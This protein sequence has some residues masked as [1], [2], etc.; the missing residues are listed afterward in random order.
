MAVSKSSGGNTSPNPPMGARQNVGNKYGGAG[1]TGNP[2]GSA[3]GPAQQYAP[4]GSPGGSPAAPA[5]VV[6]DLNLNASINQRTNTKSLPE[7]LGDGATDEQ[8]A[9]FWMQSDDYWNNETNARLDAYNQ[10]RLDLARIE[11]MYPDYARNQAQAQ[12]ILDA[13]TRV[14]TLDAAYQ[15]AKNKADTIDVSVGVGTTKDGDN[16]RV[17]KTYTITGDDGNTVSTQ[18]SEDNGG[19]S[20]S[21]LRN[22]QQQ[23]QQKALN[24]SNAY[25]ASEAANQ[26]TQIQAG[27]ERD[28]SI[29]QAQSVLDG[30]MDQYD[31]NLTNI[32][33]K[34]SADR[35]QGNQDLLLASNEIG[36][37]ATQNS[38][39]AASILS[40]YNLGGSSLAD[41]LGGIA[42]QAANDANQVAALT[43]NQRMQESDANYGDARLALEDQKAQQQ[44][45]Y[46]QS[47]AQAQA[48]YYARLAQQAGQ[49]YQDMSQYA[50]ADYWYGTMFDAQGNRMNSFADMDSQQMRD[51]AQQQADKYSGYMNSYQQQQQSAAQSQTGTKADQYTSDY[52]VPASQT[53]DAGLREYTP[54]NNDSRTVTSPSAGQQ[55]DGLQPY[56]ER[57]GETAL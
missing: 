26:V 32:D 49:N 41:R 10:A 46:N 37:Q 57:E 55:T 11:M 42:S 1:Y 17:V 16:E 24:A 25:L 53:Y 21:E 8:K 56:L 7:P 29:G 47:Q 4:G 19:M 44:N 18:Y 31:R 43:Y 36:R 54:V 50:N 12:A 33:T 52:T 23:D 39:E 6:N 40:Q 27:A 14:A 9:Q 30:Y 2:A 22:K 48:D 15:E 3:A 28:Y 38:R 51:Y 35:L 20:A 45:A 34:Y 5:N 13:R